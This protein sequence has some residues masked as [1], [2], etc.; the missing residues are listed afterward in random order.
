MT[1]EEF[2]LKLL[3]PNSGNAAFNK[4]IKQAN[5]RANRLYKKA[6][7][8]FESRTGENCDNNIIDTVND[9]IYGWCNVICEQVEHF[10]TNKDFGC[11]KFEIKKET[12]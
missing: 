11:N 6:L 1:I 9:G 10:K 12:R 4:G 8:D 7:D 5:S 3:D 2:K